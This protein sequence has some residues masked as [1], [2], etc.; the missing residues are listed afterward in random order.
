MQIVRIYFDR[1]EQDSLDNILWTLPYPVSAPSLCNDDVRALC[2]LQ[3]ASFTPAS[4]V[5]IEPAKGQLIAI[6]VHSPLGP[7][8][9]I[10][11]IQFVYG[12]GLTT[13]CGTADDT[14]TLAF[15]LD[16]AEQLTQVTVY[17][18]GSFVHHLKVGVG[19]NIF[20]MALLL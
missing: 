3:R 1:N 9:G 12:S 2:E 4:T 13:G 17:K 8:A 20:L 14:A 19:I 10:S 5:C 18:I 11:G 6:K 16:E 7:G 15:F